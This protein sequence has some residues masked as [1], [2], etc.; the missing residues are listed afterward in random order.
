MLE[1]LK[2]N[3]V[4]ASFFLT[5]NFLRIPA[6]KSITDRIIA[7]GHYTGAHSNKHLL[8]CDWTKRDSLLIDYQ[9][10]TNDLKANYNELLK[11]GIVPEKAHYFMPP[12]EWY[13]SKIVEWCTKVGLEVVNFTPGTGT[14][15]DYTTPEMKNY[16]TSEEIYTRLMQFE[17]QENLNRAIILIHPGT[18]A[19]R[20]DKFYFKL[21]NMI[22]LLKKNGYR[23]CSF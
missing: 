20:T 10:F 5:G 12:F 14:N 19:K 6:Y 11:F 3:K 17:T 21:D 9:E 18:E 8:Y 16:K 7:D 1:T 22:E 23:F 15:A 2:K 13:N 4:I